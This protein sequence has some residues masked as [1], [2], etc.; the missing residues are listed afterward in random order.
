MY[1][2]EWDGGG[3]GY[4]S[5]PPTCLWVHIAVNTIWIVHWVG[6]NHRSLL[7]EVMPL[8]LMPLDDMVGFHWRVIY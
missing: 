7:G 5:G 3:V 8:L 1:F 4:T 6:N 2:L